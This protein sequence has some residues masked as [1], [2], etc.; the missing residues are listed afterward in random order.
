M[1]ASVPACGYAVF[2]LA[3]NA[4]AGTGLPAGTAL[5]TDVADEYGEKIPV[6]TEEDVF[7]APDTLEAVFESCDEDDYIGLIMTGL[8]QRSRKGREVPAAGFRSL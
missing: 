6:E 2:G 8:W 3:D 7:V 4:R 5:K 1:K